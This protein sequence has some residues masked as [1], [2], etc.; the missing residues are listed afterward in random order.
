MAR[1]TKMVDGRQKFAK[2]LKK[3][4]KWNRVVL[5]SHRQRDIRGNQWHSD[6]DFKAIKKVFRKHHREIYGPNGNDGILR[7]LM[8]SKAYNKNGHTVN[9]SADPQLAAWIQEAVGERTG[10]HTKR[11]SRNHL[12]EGLATHGRKNPTHMKKRA[13]ALYFTVQFGP[14]GKAK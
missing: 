4:S 1:T 8:D 9:L 14:D 7:R 2:G 11:Y 13:K 5:K 6:A 12:T 3:G 10:S